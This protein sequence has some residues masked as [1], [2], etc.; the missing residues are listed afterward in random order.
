MQS[1]EAALAREGARLPLGFGGEGSPGL[2]AGEVWVWA[3]GGER[4][5]DNPGGED[6]RLFSAAAPIAAQLVRAANAFD[7]LVEAL[8]MVRDADDD[9]RVDG[10]KTLPAGPRA[11]IDA[12]L[13]KAGIS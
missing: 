6:T 5:I 10:L 13:K 9:C 1:L 4:T 8:E 7:D 11:K 12:A 2:A 3:A